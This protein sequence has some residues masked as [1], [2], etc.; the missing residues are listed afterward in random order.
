VAVRGIAAGAG[1]VLEGFLM[2][3]Q[4]GYNDGGMR[5][6]RSSHREKGLYSIGEEVDERG[7]KTE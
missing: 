3:D 2:L 1:T 7:K 4:R 6:Y 5:Y